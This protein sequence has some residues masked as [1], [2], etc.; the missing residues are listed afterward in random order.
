MVNRSM[1]SWRLVLS[2]APQGPILEQVL[3][4][5]LINDID[6]GIECALSKFADDTKLNGEVGV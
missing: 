1:P 3:L 4:S 2:G 6:S 5:I